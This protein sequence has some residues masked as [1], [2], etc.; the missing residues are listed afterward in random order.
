[1]RLTYHGRLSGRLMTLSFRLW[2]ACILLLAVGARAG[3][4]APL[5][6]LGEAIARGDYPKTT[7]VL[8]V[9]DSKLVFEGYYGDG[10]PEV[11]ND[12]RSAM[13]AV[14]ALAV[15]LAMRDG[16]IES[17]QA[18]AFRFL[19]DLKPFQN[20]TADKEAITLADMLSM[21]SALDCDDNQDDSP[22]NE[23]RMHEQQNWTR[24]AADLPTMKD[25]ARDASGI[26]P[27]RY[28]TANAFLAG[29][30]VQRATHTAIDRFVEDRVL[31]PLGATRWEWP[32]SP[33][34]EVMTGGGLLLT[35]RTLANLAWMMTD[36][37]R[38]HGRQIVP[39]RWIDEMLTA[40]RASRP[41]QNYGYFIFQGHYRTACGSTPAWYMAGNGGSQILILRAL[42]AAVVVTRTNYNVRGTSLQ[43]QDLL[44]KYV[45]PTLPCAAN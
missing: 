36:N 34:G 3:V 16:A 39:A 22:G 31:R 9:R 45:L 23:D 33:A 40:R 8:V 41:D 13:K 29:Q 27:W 42:H 5:S 10:G 38:W 1:M 21:T 12:T 6:G 20:D 18:P 24:W 14:T 7:S 15:G 35:S 44:E 32:H 17:V 37:G 26:G 11:L 2:A 19:S 30:I 28:C 43:T 25:Y 4:P